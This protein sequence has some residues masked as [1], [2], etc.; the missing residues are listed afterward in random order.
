[1]RRILIVE[2]EQDIADLIGFNLERAGFEVLKAY[3]GIKGCELALRERPDLI[4][5][6]VML[7]GR[8]GY[9]VFREIRRDPRHAGFGLGQREPTV[10]IGI[11]LGKTL[12]DLLVP[13][14]VRHGRPG[15]SGE[16]RGGEEFSVDRVHVCH[17][18]L[19]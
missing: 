16:D 9:S 17:A 13:R 8:D 14:I 7:P 2:D 4:V 5:L 12:G 11:R 3:D 15:Q 18:S 19:S 1:M 10:M 6:D